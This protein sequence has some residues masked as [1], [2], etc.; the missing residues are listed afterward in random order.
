M[1]RLVTGFRVY[2]SVLSWRSA[3]ASG[4]GGGIYDYPSMANCQ[5][6]AS[7]AKEQLDLRSL[8]QAATFSPIGRSSSPADMPEPENCT[9][10][11][12]NKRPW[13]WPEKGDSHRMKD[14]LEINRTNQYTDRA[15]YDSQDYL[16]RPTTRDT[17]EAAETLAGHPID[18]RDYSYH[19]TDPKYSRYKQ[20]DNS[21]RDDYV[22]GRPE[23][24]SDNIYYA[25]ERRLTKERKDAHMA[26]LIA[27]K[28]KAP[29]DKYA[30]WDLE[31][32]Q[33]AKDYARARAAAE[34][35]DRNPLRAFGHGRRGNYDPD[36][37][38][39]A[40]SKYEEAK[41]SG[42]QSRYPW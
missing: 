4:S 31:V 25:D 27:D 33:E 12:K 5:Y 15:T 37:L 7:K 6:S 40:V 20:V 35:G 18:K 29:I 14:Y 13:L 28:G 26:K 39:G 34:R 41:R 30:D 10:N 42:L 16:R 38:E 8:I 2:T 1:T 23:K 36:L 24:D 9:R 22:T 32:A 19:P 21:A 11:T 17:R 3:N